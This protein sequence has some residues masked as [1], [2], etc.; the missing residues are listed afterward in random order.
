M[1][2]TYLQ[3]AI[4]SPSPRGDMGTSPVVSGG[5]LA[6]A[7]M[8]VA[9]AQ[10]A[11]ASVG[12]APEVHGVPDGPDYVLPSGVRIRR[13][14]IGG[15]RVSDEKLLQAIRGVQLMPMAHQQLIAR[16][17]VPVL[18]VPT[19]RLEQVAG[20]TSPILGATSISHDG[21]TWRPTMVRIATDSPISERGGVH[22]IDEVTQH[23]LGH[24][25]SVV[26]TQDRSEQA[27]TRYAATY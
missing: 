17:G 22:A 6:A 10:A 4:A 19:Q 27:A 14:R 24:V 18:L 16:L 23:E 12:A 15:R 1:D 11:P 9:S 8:L 5:G 26:T 13:S 20:T 3:P 21:Q 7:R 2:V 25:L